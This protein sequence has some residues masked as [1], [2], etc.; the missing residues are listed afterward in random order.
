MEKLLGC[1]EGGGDEWDGFREDWGGILGAE[2]ERLL[3]RN[4][5]EERVF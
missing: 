4:V 3:R 1:C 5:M 2:E